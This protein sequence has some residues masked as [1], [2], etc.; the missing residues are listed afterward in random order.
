MTE[1]VGWISDDTWKEI[2]DHV[3]I[4]SVDLIVRCQGGILLARRQNKPAK[5][6]WFVPGGRIWKGE[7]IREAVRRI[8]KEEL[9]VEVSIERYLGVYEHFYD[10]ADVSNTSGKHYIAHGFVVEPVSDD[11]ELDNQ[12]NDVR[13]FSTQELP[14]FHPYVETYLL[15]AG[16]LKK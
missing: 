14:S 11:F 10:T 1:Q 5:G 15:D 16:L 6:E 8:S 2:V 13:I 3:P 7:R 12:H 9:G 4:P